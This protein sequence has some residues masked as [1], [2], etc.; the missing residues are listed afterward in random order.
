VVFQATRPEGRT[1]RSGRAAS[2]PTSADVTDLAREVS[3]VM[4]REEFATEV[5]RTAI[6]SGRWRPGQ[7]L[8][9]DLIAEQLGISRMPVRSGLRQLES[10]G[11]VEF[12]PYRGASVRL[13]TA[14][15]IAEIYELRIVLE[16]RLLEAAVM[17]LSSERVDELTTVALDVRH[18]ADG[19]DSWVDQRNIF[20][21]DLY[22]LADLPRISRLVASLRREVG[23]YLAL[24]PR[25]PHHTHIGVLEHLATGDVE[26][27]KS[28]LRA[29]LLR[30]SSELQELVGR[31]ADA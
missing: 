11:L 9:Q 16:S 13:L 30:V 20:Y 22:R 8:A 7:R 17:N 26:S 10:E 31:L 1:G 6:V 24:R 15:E 18:H 21:D 4:T 28:V 5:M 19:D 3:G 29:H 23:P 25:I 27:A 2:I 14:R 12:H